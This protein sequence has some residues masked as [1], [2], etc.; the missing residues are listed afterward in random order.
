VLGGFSQ[1]AVMTYALGLGPGRPRPAA[2][3][4]LSGFMPTVSRLRVRHDTAFA[5]G[6]DRSRCARPGD[7]RR[8]GPPCPQ[9]LE[10]AGASIIYREAPI[11]HMVDP[12]FL[13]ELRPWLVEALGLA[14]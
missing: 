3:I 5:A 10:Q 13:D 6:R 8:V 1:G 11:P 14:P 9:T 4:A 12:A 7:L 2:L